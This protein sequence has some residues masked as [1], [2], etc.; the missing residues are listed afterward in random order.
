VGTAA[1]ATTAAGS[2]ERH[3]GL[4]PLAGQLLAVA[5]AALPALGAVV[6]AIAFAVGNPAVADASAVAAPL[7]ELALVGAYCVAFVAPL[8]VVVAALR[9]YGPLV[10][11]LLSRLVV[12]RA[13]RA[14][15]RRTLWRALTAIAA[16]VIVVLAILAVVPGFPGTTLAFLAAFGLGSWCADRLDRDELVFSRAWPAL[17]VVLLVT[18]TGLGLAGIVPGVSVVHVVFADDLPVD[19]GNFILVGESD[20]FVHLVPCD[21]PATTVRV[22]ADG[23]EVVAGHGA[24]AAPFRSAWQALADR[25]V[26]D[27]G[28]RRSCG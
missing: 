5:T 3:D 12:G 15:E 6:R 20:E 14:T 2:T 21:G 13:D 18:S 11:S 16:G 28:I 27:L 26:P 24:A 8:A 9:H 25:D 4:L 23:I 17:L 10:E 19:E 7:S 1:A 22:R